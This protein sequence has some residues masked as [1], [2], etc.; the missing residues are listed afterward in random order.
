MAATSD[1]TSQE[2]HEA[3]DAEKEAL[4]QA[5]SLYE[6][7]P[8]PPLP[9]V[10]ARESPEAL[11]KSVPG[12]DLRSL[13]K[14]K[15]LLDHEIEDR[16]RNIT[17]VSRQNMVL[18]QM[19]HMVKDSNDSNAHSARDHLMKQSQCLKQ[20]RGRRDRYK[21]L[22]LKA[23]ETRKGLPRV[24]GELERSRVSYER[25][26][27]RR[28]SLDV[29]LGTK[30]Q[31]NAVLQADVNEYVERLALRRQADCIGQVLYYD[32]ELSGPARE[33]VHRVNRRVLRE[34]FTCLKATA[35]RQHRLRSF[36]ERRIASHAARLKLMSFLGLYMFCRRSTFARRCLQ[37]RKLLLARNVFARWR[38]FHFVESCGRLAFERRLKTAVLHGWSEAARGG[39]LRGRR[40]NRLRE[41]FHTWRGGSSA[42]HQGGRTLGSAFETWHIACVM[43]ASQR[44]G[45]AEAAHRNSLLKRLLRVWG[46][47]IK[48]RPAPSLAALLQT[49]EYHWRARRQMTALRALHGI[50]SSSLAAARGYSRPSKRKAGFLHWRSV[51]A[52]AKLRVTCSAAARSFHRRLLTQQACSSWASWAKH[53]RQ[54]RV[55]QMRLSFH[56]WS[57]FVCR[58]R[59]KKGAA[60]RLV[61]AM[62]RCTGR[63]ARSAWGIWVHHIKQVSLTEAAES[64]TAQRCTRRRLETAF[65]HWLACWVQKQV[66]FVGVEERAA[67]RSGKRIEQLEDELERD[68]GLAAWER[69]RVAKAEQ[70]MSR[71]SSLVAEKKLELGNMRE[72]T[73]QA[74]AKIKAAKAEI[75]TLSG[76]LRKREAERKR[77]SSALSAAKALE[78][79]NAKQ[80]RLHVKQALDSMDKQLKAL[81]EEANCGRSKVEATRVA[82]QDVQE[83]ESTSLA[84]VLDAGKMHKA[85][86]AASLSSLEQ[87]HK[88]QAALEHTRQ[89]V[90][91]SM[92]HVTKNNQGESVL[93]KD[94]R[95]RESR[96]S[97]LRVR[98]GEL[99]ARAK[100]AAVL[101]S[102]RQMQLVKLRH[103]S[104]QAEKKGAEERRDYAR[105]APEKV[106][107]EPV[108]EE[109]EEE[110]RSQFY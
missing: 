28:E 51:T 90:K 16:Q 74:K 80:R 45:R 56:A 106:N 55:K 97:A 57:C 79:K 3:W 95:E 86:L 60:M 94:A 7:P 22:I 70:V 19:L 63:A 50:N 78:L 4:Q 44:L 65:Q 110:P 91:Q 82:L 10:G 34:R 46:R 104:L 36:V 93:S 71:T 92:E 54:M 69:E 66:R 53:R 33:L 27:G 105:R 41:A 43:L 64:L 59:S 18:W 38:K 47:I 37:R 108:E 72:E 84:K 8:L 24:M 48:S 83:R 9:S 67:L 62:K 13:H 23:R 85:A 35:M 30:T 58:T 103:A 2:E 15:L 11:T 5:L 52:E 73:A 68:K 40:Q 101:L 88:R 98:D 31:S 26:K 89:Q 76:D 39:Q 25:A 102:E 109:E 107:Q 75:K 99:D 17:T 29:T 20:L 32:P 12:F 14:Q 61:L 6:A 77:L 100:E 49:G 1:N 96:V 81:Q 42:S 87:L 21:E